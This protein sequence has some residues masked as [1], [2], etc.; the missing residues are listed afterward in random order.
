[1]GGEFFSHLLKI[2]V[3]SMQPPGNPCGELSIQW[4][5]H[6]TIHF[7]AMFFMVHTLNF[8]FGWLGFIGELTML[9]DFKISYIYINSHIDFNLNKK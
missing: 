6:C 5:Y 3:T 4:L 9:Q 1:M 2:G 8:E 7:F